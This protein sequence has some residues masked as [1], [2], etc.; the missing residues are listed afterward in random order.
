MIQVLILVH[1]LVSVALLGAITHQA[2]SAGRKHGPGQTFVRRFMGVNSPS[3]TNV[4]I[5]LFFTTSVLGGLAYPDY[6]VDVR[7]ILEGLQLRWANGLF[8]MKEHFAAVGLGLL[9]A[10]WLAWRPPLRFENMD[11]RKYLSWILAFIVWFNFI[12]GEVLNNI[13]GLM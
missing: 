13:Q 9:P 3:F 10:Y 7:P 8:E 4:V 12:V 11:T 2:F 5:L 6:R 1:V